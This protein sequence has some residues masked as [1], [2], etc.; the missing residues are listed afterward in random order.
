MPNYEKRRDELG[1]R[2]LGVMLG[3]ELERWPDVMPEVEREMWRLRAETMDAMGR[4]P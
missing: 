4:D 3:T 1:I 2:L